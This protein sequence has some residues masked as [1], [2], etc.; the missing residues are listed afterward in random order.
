M[1]LIAGSKFASHFLFHF[2]H[3]LSHFLIADSIGE[4]AQVGHIGLCQV[5]IAAERGTANPTV[6]RSPRSFLPPPLL[7]SPFSLSVPE[8]FLLLWL[9]LTDY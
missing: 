2:L 5:F 7:F 6:G 3:H 1:P 4:D 9:N 8:Y